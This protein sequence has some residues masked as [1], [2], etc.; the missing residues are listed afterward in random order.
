MDNW[1]VKGRVPS[2]AFAGYYGH[3]EI[4]FTELDITLYVV[5]L[6]Q[7]PRAKAHNSGINTLLRICTRDRMHC[8]LTAPCYFSCGICLKNILVDECSCRKNIPGLG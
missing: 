6:R 1:P 7:S 4:H 5:E 2:A 8:P 3:R